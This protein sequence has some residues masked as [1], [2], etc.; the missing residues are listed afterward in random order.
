LA[1]ADVGV[2][3][4]FPML[5]AESGDGAI[6]IGTMPFAEDSGV[7]NPENADAGFAIP[8]AARGGE[9]ASYLGGGGGATCLVFS[10]RALDAGE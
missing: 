2:M 5:N 10:N 7:E 9:M 4:T 8:V 3:V 6:G 1:G